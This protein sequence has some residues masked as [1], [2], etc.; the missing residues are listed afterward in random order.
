MLPSLQLPASMR[1]LWVKIGGLWPLNTGG[2]LR[3]YHIVSELSRRHR[4]VLLTPHGPEDDPDGL[5]TNL[6]QCE[7]VLSVP[8][9]PPKQ[10]SL[11]LA[12]SL[13]GSWFSELPVDM[14]KW[15]VPAVAEEVRHL[16][17]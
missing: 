9:R 11:K 12:R 13:V 14:W 6:P 17:E 4:V 2:R 7:R 8:H 10:G 15:R 16:L 1:I 5:R 3:S